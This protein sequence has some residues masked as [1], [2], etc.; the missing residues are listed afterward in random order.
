MRDA[1]RDPP[2]RWGHDPLKNIGHLVTL[3]EQD[4][5]YLSWTQ[6]VL[7]ICPLEEHRTLTYEPDN[8]HR[9]WSQHVLG[10]WLEK[11]SE[12]SLSVECYWLV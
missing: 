5:T 3:C 12:T 8:T 2:A 11:A 6:H 10:I 1:D 9:R 7:G 4:Y